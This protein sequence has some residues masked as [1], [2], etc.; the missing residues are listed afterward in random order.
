MT[1]SG[2]DVSS[3]SGESSAATLQSFDSEFM[4]L[5]EQ[6]SKVVVSLVT[7]PSSTAC[8]KRALLADITRL[9]VFM[10]RQ[11]TNDLLLPLLITFLNDRETALRVA[12]FESISGVCVFVGQASLQAFVMPCILQSLTDVEEAVVAAALASLCRLAEVS[13]HTRS[14][15]ID[16]AGKIAPLLTHPSSWVRHGALG[17]FQ[18]VGNHFSPSETYCLIRPILR[19]FLAR[20]FLSL[21]SDHLAAALHPPVSRLA[22][23]QALACAAEQQQQ[24]SQLLAS[25]GV[26]VPGAFGAAGAAGGAGGGAVGPA[27]SLDDESFD[28]QLLQHGAVYMLDVTADG[29]SGDGLGGGGGADGGVGPSTVVPVAVSPSSPPAS[30][31]VSP[32]AA[33][34]TNDAAVAAAA[35]GVSVGPGEPLRDGPRPALDGGPRAGGGGVAPIDARAYPRGVNREDGQGASVGE[36]EQRVAADGGRRRR[37]RATSVPHASQYCGC[38]RKATTHPTSSH[39]RRATMAAS[40]SAGGATCQGAGVGGGVMMSP[41]ARRL[42]ALVWWHVPPSCP[43]LARLTRRRREAGAADGRRATRAAA[44]G[45]VTP[46]SRGRPRRCDVASSDSSLEGALVQG[47]SS[48]SRGPLRGGRAAPA[49]SR[50][51]RRISG[52]AGGSTLSGH[53]VGSGAAGTGG[54]CHRPAP[55]LAAA[56]RT[57]QVAAEEAAAEAAAAAAAARADRSTTA[58]GRWGGACRLDGPERQRAPS[59]PR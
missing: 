42:V 7:D 58:R 16:I 29:A 12:F 13:L 52:G 8:V 1:A 27:P 21:D 25:G 31:A 40:S 9:C 30:A 46:G 34:L 18:S 45:A 50:R 15:L 36:R 24:H 59:S 26:A 56:A 3:D 22:F 14:S 54:A 32:P 44:A 39:R 37:W 41:R 10:A 20:P 35:A 19:P 33:A 48:A 28:E 4:S 47:A 11:N 57:L 55:T 2:G 23:D 53:L 49:D 43:R 6:V 17:F 51:R 38:T 5:Q